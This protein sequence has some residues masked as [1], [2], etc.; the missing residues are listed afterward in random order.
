MVT[1]RWSFSDRKE[2]PS[3]PTMA[4]DAATAPIPEMGLLGCP[5]DPQDGCRNLLPALLCVQA[6]DFLSLASLCGCSYCVSR[7]FSCPQVAAVAAAER[8]LLGR[9]EASQVLPLC[10]T[11]QGWEGGPPHTAKPSSRSPCQFWKTTSEL[12][13]PVQLPSHQSCHQ[14]HPVQLGAACLCLLQGS[15]SRPFPRSSLAPSPGVGRAGGSSLW[16]MA[17]DRLRSFTVV[18][19]RPL[20]FVPG[21]GSFSQPASLRRSRFREWSLGGVPSERAE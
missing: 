14:P 8:G 4:V 10:V 17:A 19:Q 1:N 7:V 6:Q 9:Q 16:P 18:S 20:Y 11:K 3:V 2:L 5:S 12:K 13:A 21:R 15:V